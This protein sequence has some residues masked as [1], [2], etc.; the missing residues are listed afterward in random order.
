M[1]VSLFMTRIL[2]KI[3][4]TCW[5]LLANSKQKVKQNY[6]FLVSTFGKIVSNLL[7]SNPVCSSFKS[8]KSFFFYF[9]LF[10]VK[11]GTR[12][13]KIKCFN[14]LIWQTKQIIYSLKNTNTIFIRCVCVYLKRFSFYFELKKEQHNKRAT[15][16]TSSIKILLIFK[17]MKFLFLFGEHL[18]Y[19]SSVFIYLSSLNE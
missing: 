2:I 14:R 10:I 7:Q 15:T 17:N 12:R 1:S 3:L 16:T 5:T 13:I 8:L 18:I 4:Q 6:Q 11:Y 19:Y 9:L